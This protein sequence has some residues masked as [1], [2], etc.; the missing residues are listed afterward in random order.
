MPDSTR[1][2]RR[3]VARCLTL[4]LAL[5]AGCAGA[6]APVLTWIDA[7]FDDLD[8]FALPAAMTAGGSGTAG[9]DAAHWYAAP[10]GSDGS[11]RCLRVDAPGSTGQQFHVLLTTAPFATRDLRLSVRIRADAGEEDQGGGL[12]WRALDH[13]DYYIARWNPLE[14]NVRLYTVVGGVRTMLANAD[15]DVPHDGWHRLGVAVQGAHLTVL[16]DDEALFSV[17]DTTFAGTGR[18]GLWTKADASTSFDD[19]VVR[20]LD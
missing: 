13:D 19:L 11:P 5:P 12:C 18:V 2:V 3:R 17:R 15:V 16:L 9:G 20:R 7:D 14:D 8:A 6:P 1:P 4:A 10:D